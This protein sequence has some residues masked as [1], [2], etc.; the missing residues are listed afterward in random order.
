MSNVDDSNKGN[1][2]D[3]GWDH[4][5]LIDPNNPKQCN[6]CSKVTKG[7]IS[8]H[9]EMVEEK[10]LTADKIGTFVKQRGSPVELLAKLKE[11]GSEFL[12]NE[13][14]ILFKALA[15]SECIH[16]VV[17]DLSLARGL[18]YYTGVIYEAVFKGST[19]VGSIAALGRY[20]N[21]IRMFGTKQ[22]PAVGISLGVERVFAIMEQLQKDKNQV[23]EKS[24]QCIFSSF[25]EDVGATFVIRQ[26]G[27]DDEANKLLMNRNLHSNGLVTWS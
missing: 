13:L 19:Q 27:I 18:D 25:D 1:K 15:K 4:G 9:K 2:K 12:T 23:F 11:E 26:W 6:Y 7:G 8:R 16:R 5:H 14:D 3:P 24:V 17:F 22:V 10:G 21:L 20:D